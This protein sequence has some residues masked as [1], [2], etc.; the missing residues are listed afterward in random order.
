MN[1]SQLPLLSP[2]NPYFQEKLCSLGLLLGERGLLRGWGSDG[3]CWTVGRVI[4]CRKTNLNRPG[5]CGGYLV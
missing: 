5:F 2:A 4:A 3:Y 1:L